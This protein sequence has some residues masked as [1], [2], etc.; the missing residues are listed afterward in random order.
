MIVG[1]DGGTWRAFAVLD[2]D[3]KL[4]A[5]KSRKN[6]LPGEF[7]AEVSDYLPTI[8]ACDKNPAPRKVLVLKSVFGARLFKPSKN[9]SQLQKHS[10]TRDFKVRN[11][12]ERDALA[13]AIKAYN[14]VA[15]KISAVEKKSREAG[16]P[17]EQRLS[18]KRMVLKGETVANA[19]KSL[20]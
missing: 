7:L 18:V 13:S 15:A 1:V 11:S 14:S 5:L 6:W 16:V 3:G 19:I 12:H 8:I 9:L 2:F 20:G 10:L 17:A 4:V